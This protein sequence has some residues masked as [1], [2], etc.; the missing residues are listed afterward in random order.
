MFTTM[1]VVNFQHFP[2]IISILYFLLFAVAYV[3]NICFVKKRIT[4]S[5]C[6]FMTQ[7]IHVHLISF[8]NVSN[9]SNWVITIYILNIVTL[10]WHFWTF[11]IY[12]FE[13]FNVVQKMHIHVKY[14]AKIKCYRSYCN[15]LYTSIKN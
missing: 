8:M 2:F 14:T 7:Y 1:R 3:K 15:L 11:W 12:W 5:F 4:V 9:L 10:L 6:C 13:F